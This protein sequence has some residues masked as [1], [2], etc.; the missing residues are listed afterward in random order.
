MSQMEDQPQEDSLAK[1]MTWADYAA[2]PG[3]GPTKLIGRITEVLAQRDGDALFGYS[4]N[5]NGT[6]ITIWADQSFED[7]APGVALEFVLHHDDDSAAFDPH[8]LQALM[9]ASM[10]ANFDFAVYDQLLEL[11]KK[12]PYFF[13][14]TN[15]QL[16]SFMR[17]GQ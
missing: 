6:P 12:D 2:A 1:R 17:K 13:D 11:F 7:A 15:N 4:M 3:V 14:P 16:Y 5:C 8:N 10:G 9:A